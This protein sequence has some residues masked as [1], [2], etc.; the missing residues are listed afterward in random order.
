MVAFKQ[1]ILW[2]MS[3]ECS[4]KYAV[5]HRDN[6]CSRMYAYIYIQTI[7]FDWVFRGSIDKHIPGI[8]VDNIYKL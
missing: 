8:K 3:R 2:R 7:W 6:I 1:N 4:T 5:K